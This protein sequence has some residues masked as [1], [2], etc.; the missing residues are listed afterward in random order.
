MKRIVVNFGSCPC[1]AIGAGQ[2]Y[3]NAAVSNQ[4]SLSR[5]TA[6]PRRAGTMRRE[7]SLAGKL[8]SEMTSMR[9]TMTFLLA[10]GSLAGC[11]YEQTREVNATPPTVSYQVYGNDISQAN[12]QADRY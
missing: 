6:K 8:L 12:A 7:S 4:A 9:A 1:S 2:R 10:L 5:D 11:A 3:A